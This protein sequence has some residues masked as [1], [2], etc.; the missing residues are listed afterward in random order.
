MNAKYKIDSRVHHDGIC[1]T[2]VNSLPNGVLGEW[3]YIVRRTDGSQLSFFRAIPE[4]ELTP[5]DCEQPGGICDFCEEIRQDLVQVTD[6]T[7]YCPR[8]LKTITGRKT[9]PAMMPAA[10]TLRVSEP[11]K[12]QFAEGDQVRVTRTRMLSYVQEVRGEDVMLAGG[13][14]YH[15]DEL[16][17]IRKAPKKA[18][19]SV[20]EEYRTFVVTRDGVDI[21]PECEALSRA[22]FKVG[23]TVRLKG[24]TVE[25][26]IK[27][28]V[29]QRTGAYQRNVVIK[30][31]V[32]AYGFNYL[33]A[34]D[35]EPVSPPAPAVVTPK[36]RLEPLPGKFQRGQW[37]QTAHGKGRVLGLGAPGLYHVAIGS[38]R[39]I[40][41]EEYMQ[42]AVPNWTLKP[43]VPTWEEAT[44]QFNTRMAAFR[45]K[46]AAELAR[47]KADILK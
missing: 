43:G 11:L 7:R 29:P 37:V 24:R 8:C 25:T 28:V 12:T 22:P 14:W 45:A 38:R 2:V 36:P 5:C 47:A 18:L 4:N 15:V 3:G 31:V 27:K 40:A 19:C 41:R 20:C 30:Y 34:K 6:T 46:N 33:T 21:C 10:T 13:N 32:A 9:T 26:T 16:T 17:L 39:I 44:A 35:L 23:D 1:L 42:A